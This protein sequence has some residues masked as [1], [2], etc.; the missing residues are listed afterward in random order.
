MTVKTHLDCDKPALSF[1]SAEGG[2]GVV[3]GRVGVTS[4]AAAWLTVDS[5]LFAPECIMIED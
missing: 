3:N 1:A 2:G 4:V 5:C